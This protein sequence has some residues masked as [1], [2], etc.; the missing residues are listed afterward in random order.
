MNKSGSLKWL[1][2]FIIQLKLRE[3]YIQFNSI[4]FLFT[5]YSKTRICRDYDCSKSRLVS[6]IFFI[7]IIEIVGY[8]LRNR[9]FAHKMYCRTRSYRQS[10]I[11]GTTNNIIIIDRTQDIWLVFH[12]R[13]VVYVDIIPNTHNAGCVTLFCDNSRFFWTEETKIWW[14]KVPPSREGVF[15]RI[16]DCQF[17]IA[18]PKIDSVTNIPSLCASLSLKLL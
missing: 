15:L 6:K 14:K 9:G 2:V 10:H 12:R 18:K 3:K 1:L 4:K 13:L 7:H 5:Q 11:Y 17:Y 16:R 8:D